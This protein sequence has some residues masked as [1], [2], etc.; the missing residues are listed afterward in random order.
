MLN[1]T[2]TLSIFSRSGIFTSDLESIAD[3]IIMG[4]KNNSAS[5][6]ITMMN[7]DPV[8]AHLTPVVVVMPP[9][10]IIIILALSHR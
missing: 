8:N 5:T 1:F 7:M 10:L 6:E 3:E 2:F 4:K 9:F